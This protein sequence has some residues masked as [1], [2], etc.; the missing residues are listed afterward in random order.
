MQHALGEEVYVR[1]TKRPY[2]IGVISDLD[3][4]LESLGRAVVPLQAL[5]G[6]LQALLAS[7]VGG[8]AALEF[9]QPLGGVVIAAHFAQQV[10]I[11]LGLVQGIAKDL[12]GGVGFA[13]QAVEEIANP[14]E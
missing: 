10:V 3:R 13:R 12:L 6:A 2:R 5:E 7:G 1:Y 8:L 4:F 9:D 14:L 11:Q